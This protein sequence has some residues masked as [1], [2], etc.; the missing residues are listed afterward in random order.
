MFLNFV[1]LHQEFLYIL[2]EFYITGQHKGTHD[3]ESRLEVKIVKVRHG[4]VLHF[5]L[6]A[7]FSLLIIQ[8]TRRA[9]LTIIFKV[10]VGL[11][12]LL[13]NVPRTR[14][15]SKGSR[16]SSVVAPVLW[17]KLPFRLD[18][19]TVW[20]VLNDFLKPFFD[21]IQL[22]SDAVTFLFSFLTFSFLFVI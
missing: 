10:T 17:N 14:L 13:L 9:S 3:S 18:L 16:A 22:R 20:V 4:F 7:H 5:S 2:L 15:R 1:T 8:T 6:F 21:G 11:N 19:P 12:P